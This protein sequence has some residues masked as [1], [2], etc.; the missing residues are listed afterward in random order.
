M[1]VMTNHAAVITV[2]DDT[3]DHHLK[4]TPLWSNGMH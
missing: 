1:L 4:A 2:P 3:T